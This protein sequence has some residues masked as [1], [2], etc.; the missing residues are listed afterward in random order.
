MKHV[1]LL[2]LFV[3][4]SAATTVYGQ[5]FKKGTNVIALGIGLGSSL[6]YSYGSISPAFSAQYEKGLWEVGPGV[7]SLGGYLGFISQKN[8]G[9]YYRQKWSYTIIGV[10]SAYHYTGFTEGKLANLDVYAGVMASYHITSYKIDYYGTGG[11]G[12]S[13][14]Y[15]SALDANVYVGG[16]YYFTKNIAGF[17]E[18]GY[19]ISYLTIGLAFKF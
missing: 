3:L 1:K 16:R 13:G 19:G 11:Q 15:P 5:A 12:F 6:S 10:R 2:L 9:S 18:A 8:T 14:D 4:F 7:I 17:A